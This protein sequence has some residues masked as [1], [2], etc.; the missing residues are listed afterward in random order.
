MLAADKAA[1][2][3]SLK[4]RAIDIQEKELHFFVDNNH[5]IGEQSSLLAGFSFAAFTMTGFT[6]LEGQAKVFKMAYY[7]MAVLSMTCHLCTVLMA[8]LVS[9]FIFHLQCTN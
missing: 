7:G 6:G 8:T 4:K 2:E 9:P 5:S 1:L 3:S